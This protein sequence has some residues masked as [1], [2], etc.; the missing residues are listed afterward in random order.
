MLELF[1]YKNVYMKLFILPIALAF[2]SFSSCSQDIAADKVPSVVQNTVH[3]KFINVGKI[4]W[5]KKNNNL[6]EAEFDMDST[7]YNI[8]IDTAGK[9]I[10]H[11]IGISTIELPAAV[12]TAIS[13]GYSGYKIEEAEKL[14]KDGVSYYQVELEA[15]GKKEQQLIFSPD[16]KI[17]TGITDIK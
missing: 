3:A 12:I 1:T 13:D 15:K 2:F 5:E 8:L 9:I 17:A 4:D 16:G 11:K 14:E 10:M 6:Y 7:E